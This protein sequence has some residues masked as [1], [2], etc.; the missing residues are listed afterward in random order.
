MIVYERD[1]RFE[2]KRPTHY[3]DPKLYF[4]SLIFYCKD[5]AK[6]TQS[7]IVIDKDASTYEITFT[8]DVFDKFICDG[9]TAHLFDSIVRCSDNISIYTPEDKCGCIEIKVYYM[10]ALD[11]NEEVYD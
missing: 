6:E 10:K 9:L 3:L 5:L 11:L 7:K 8:V 1:Y 4:E 2:H